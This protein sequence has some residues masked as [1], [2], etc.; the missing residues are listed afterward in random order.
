MEKIYDVIIIGAGISGLS[1]AHFIKKLSPSF[2]VMLLE[3]SGRAGG[4]IQSFH[5]DGFWLNGVPTGFWT[6]R[7]KAEKFLKIQAFTVRPS[8]RL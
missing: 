3:A 6:M 8:K 1:A 5:Q 2:E 4:A 7:R